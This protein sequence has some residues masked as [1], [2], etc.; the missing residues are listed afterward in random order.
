MNRIIDGLTINESVSNIKRYNSTI[1]LIESILKKRCKGSNKRIVLMK[2]VRF[3]EDF[4][5]IH[6]RLD[7]AIDKDVIHSVGSDG[8]IY[9]GYALDNLKVVIPYTDE[10]LARTLISQATQHRKERKGVSL[11]TE[12]GLNQKDRTYVDPSW[13]YDTEI[14]KDVKSKVEEIYEGNGLELKLK[15]GVYPKLKNRKMLPICF[16]DCEKGILDYC[17]SIHAETS[18]AKRGHHPLTEL[19]Y[20]NGVN[21]VVLENME[22]NRDWIVI[23]SKDRDIEKID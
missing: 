5:N 14:F 2:L 20:V 22:F 13:M 10:D 21:Y 8:N 23:E 7:F 4:F 3:T 1:R 16:I 12:I 6:I 9:I 17:Y 19:Q 18:R 15:D 11:E